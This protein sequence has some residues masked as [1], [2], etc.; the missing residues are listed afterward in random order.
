MTNYDDIAISLN[1]FRHF[2][3]T[4]YLPK[5]SLD[6]AKVKFISPNKCYTL[7]LIYTDEAKKKYI[8]RQSLLMK[9]Q[10]P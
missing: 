6:R 4:S 1:D 3:I 10:I 9:E 2:R 8:V 5:L 7:H